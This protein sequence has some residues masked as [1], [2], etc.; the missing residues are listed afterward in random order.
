MKMKFLYLIGI[1]LI[2]GLLVSCDKD[3]DI[4]SSSGKSK[5]VDFT[6]L[7]GKWKYTYGDGVKKYITFGDDGSYSVELVDRTSH[8]IP[9]TYSYNG[10]RGEIYITLQGEKEPT[11][12]K[13]CLLTESELELADAED[14]NFGNTE[15]YTKV[16]SENSEE[17][18]DDRVSFSTPRFSSITET[19]AYLNGGIHGKGVKFDSRGICYSTSPNPTVADQVIT[20][21]GD[22]VMYR[23][24]RLSNNTT[25]YVRLFA[26]L[27]GKTVYSKMNS[28]TT[29]S[30]YAPDNIINKYLWLY[31]STDN[32]TKIDVLIIKHLSQSEGLIDENLVE[33]SYS[34]TGLRLAEYF[35]KEYD[36]Y[37]N[38]KYIYQIKLIF[39]SSSSGN[40][41]GTRADTNGESVSF[42]GSF[43]F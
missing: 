20:V 13:V 33:Y 17:D 9:G 18:T 34:V 29:T 15:T 11:T 7:I 1:M 10:K 21:S 19:S 28:F 3:S 27:E 32:G 24:E 40:I 36:S 42:T 41:S 30:A 43:F 5:K 2:S 4:G 6:F 12:Y 31:P 25:Y 22:S 23:I 8:S 37:Y 14:I 16:G 26:R 38:L 35:L 39:T